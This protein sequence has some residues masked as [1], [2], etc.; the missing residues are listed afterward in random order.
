MTELTHD[1]QLWVNALVIVGLVF[2]FLAAGGYILDKQEEKDR[3]Q[4]DKRNRRRRK[5]KSQ[6]QWE[7]INSVYS[8]LGKY[9]IGMNNANAICHNCEYQKDNKCFCKDKP[10][11]FTDDTGAMADCSC[12]K[13]QECEKGQ[14]NNYSEQHSE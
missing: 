12:Y 8:A 2:T 7:D 9:Y 4:Q 6:R 13:K 1:Q 11:R 3:K 14:K 5:H 10:K